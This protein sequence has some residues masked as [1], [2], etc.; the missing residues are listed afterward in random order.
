VSLATQDTVASINELLVDA[1]ANNP[2]GFINMLALPFTFALC[3]KSWPLIPTGI[4]LR[5]RQELR[6]F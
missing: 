4:R 5:H 2:T 1:V 3:S 6:Y